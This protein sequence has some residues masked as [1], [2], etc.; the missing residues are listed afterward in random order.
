MCPDVAPVDCAADCRNLEADAAAAGCTT[1]YDDFMT[2]WASL[3]NVCTLAGSGCEDVANDFL[4]CQSGVTGG[5]M[6]GSLP[7]NPSCSALCPRYDACPDASPTCTA[8]CAESDAQAAATGCSVEYDALMGC[9]S[10]CADICALNDYD[11]VTQ[12]NDYFSC[13]ITYCAAN[14]SAAPCL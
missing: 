3:T 12:V 9:A 1:I 7:A 8:D 10:T 5:C 2:C 13:V 6:T 11:C 14:P 4:E